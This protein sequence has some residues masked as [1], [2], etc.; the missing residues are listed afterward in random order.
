MTLT[1]NS[2]AIPFWT[3]AA[4]ASAMALKHFLADFVLQS[5]WMVRGK[6]QACGWGGP[7]LA[8]AGCHAFITFVIAM[9]VAPRL[10][11]VAA[12]DLAVHATIDRAKSVVARRGGLAPEQAAFWRLLGFDQFLHN[13]TGVGLV[14]ALLVL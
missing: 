12:A 1:A 7:L 9:A 6:E 11:W 8:H 3:A 5:G 10:W 13:L 14:L 2:G 4:L